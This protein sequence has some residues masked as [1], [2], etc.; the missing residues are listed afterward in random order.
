L[1]PPQQSL[2][3]QATSQAHTASHVQASVHT[4]TVLP[5]HRCAPGM[6]SQVEG[7]GG[8]LMP[9]QQS[10]F[11]QLTSQAQTGSHVQAFVHTSTFLPL[12]RCAPGTHAQFNGV[13][14]GAPQ[15]CG[16]PCCDSVAS[17]RPSPQV[18]PQEPHE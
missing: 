4:S 10:L 9:P 13:E 8:P 6:H 11:S 3:P 2:F 5:S 14:G 12:H 16:Q 15:S 7:H 1:T 18:G 17:Q